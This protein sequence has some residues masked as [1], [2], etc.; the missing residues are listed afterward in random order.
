M[1]V[2]CA[3]PEDWIPGLQTFPFAKI[4]GG[5]AIIALLFALNGNRQRLPREVIYL[6]LLFVQLWIAVPM[7]PVW[8]GGAFNTVLDFTKVLPIVILMAL[9][10]NTIKKLR[11]LILIQAAS[12]ATIAAATIWKGHQHGGRLEGALGG[13]YGNANDLA[14]AIAIAA[15]LCLYFLFRSRSKLGKATW[16]LGIL[17]M[18]YAAFLTLSRSGLIALI[19][20]TAICLWEFAIRGR[21]RYM[22]VAALVAGIAFWV[23]VGSGLS[24]RFKGAADSTNA[25]QA[26]AYESAQQRRELLIQSLRITAEHPLFGVGPGNF[27][28]LSGNWH[29]THNS[30][31][32]MSSEGGVL[33][34]VFYLMI[35][36]RG[37]SNLAATKRLSRSSEERRIL[38]GALRASLMAFLVGSFFA[39]E[40]YLFFPYIFVAYTTALY[41][42][43]AREASEK[44]ARDKAET[45][46]PEAQETQNQLLET[47]AVWL[48]S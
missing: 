6:M 17:V 15:P 7:S 24:S 9:V 4:T 5:L 19:T 28:I 10:V 38:A 46:R 42:I 23:Y 1:V 39:S 35:I 18:V 27:P 44:R 2:Y 45:K 3:R 48:W 14:I 40:A 32:Q 47:D 22:L 8:R 36:W 31:T 34:L 33:A 20:A 11:W 30:Y 37:F 16:A 12:V 41:G 25:D 43:S 29:V 21:R 13:N 26:S